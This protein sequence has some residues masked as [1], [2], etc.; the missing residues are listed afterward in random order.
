MPR[1]TDIAPGS[2]ESS[3]EK[4]F[5]LD[6]VSGG[7][8]EVEE[9]QED[10]DDFALVSIVFVSGGGGDERHLQVPFPHPPP[11]TTMPDTEEG[12]RCC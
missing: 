5:L 3:E 11:P 1:K 7:E 12:T 8:V 2:V 10:E 6:P 9:E 4:F